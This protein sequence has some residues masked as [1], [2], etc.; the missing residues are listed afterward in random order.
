MSTQVRDPFLAVTIDTTGST[1]YRVD[2]E[3]LPTAAYTRLPAPED[4]GKF[5]VPYDLPNVPSTYT[6]SVQTKNSLHES[7]VLSESVIL[8]SDI[9]PAVSTLRNK[10]RIAQSFGPNV[11]PTTMCDEIKCFHSFI[12]LYNN[13]DT[14]ID[15]STVKLWT[16]YQNATSTPSYDVDGITLLEYITL[17]DNPVVLTNWASVTLSGTIAPNGYFLILGPRVPIENIQADTA[18]IE[19][20]LFTTG[21]EDTTNYHVDLDLSAS[22]DFYISSKLVQIVL[23]DSSVT[24]LPE[25]IYAEGAFC[26][27]FIDL[28]GCTANDSDV[29][30]ENYAVPDCILGYYDG[31]SKQRVKNLIAPTVEAVNNDTD[32]TT[33]SIKSLTSVTIRASV[34]CRPRNSNFT[35]EYV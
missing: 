30:A 20:I 21:I 10:L 6:V 5:V 24:S 25:S 23:T 15:L 12:S 13:S 9:N 2:H 22:S 11:T 8:L 19:Q 27:G 34:N 33:S 4:D 17:P 16:R 35:G 28:Y 14:E 7:A 3:N 18:A 26:A 31:N 29:V 1:H 32:Y